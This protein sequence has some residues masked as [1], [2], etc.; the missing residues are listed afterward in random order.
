MMNA[1]I[2][3]EMTRSRSHAD[4]NAVERRLSFGGAATSAAGWEISA[5]A[6]IVLQYY[7]IG[8]CSRKVSA[9][10]QR[11]CIL[12]RRSAKGTEWESPASQCRVGGQIDPSPK[13]DG[14]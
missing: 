14:T 12:R 4:I 5:P 1:E 9:I 2:A 10:N 8:C 6:A 7:W 11:R 13:R 3:S